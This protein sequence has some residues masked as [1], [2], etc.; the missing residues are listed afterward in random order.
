MVGLALQEALPCWVPDSAALWL[1]VVVV[2]GAYYLDLLD[3]DSYQ[4]GGRM[5]HT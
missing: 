5:S 3:S 2:A 1:V 4:L